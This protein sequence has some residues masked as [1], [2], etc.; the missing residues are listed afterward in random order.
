[1]DDTDWF[2]IAVYTPSETTDITETDAQVCVSVCTDTALTAGVV[3]AVV[4]ALLVA[5]ISVAIHIAVYQCLYKPRLRSSTV[6]QGST[7]ERVDITGGSESSDAGGGD[8][9]VYDVVDERV[10]SALEMK[11]NEAYGIAKSNWYKSFSV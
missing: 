2:I 8:A 4:T 9:V 3:S 10:G 1:M 6:V 7:S 5:V 11:K